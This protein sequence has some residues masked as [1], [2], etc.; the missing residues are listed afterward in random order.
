MKGYNKLPS[1][2]PYILL[3]VVKYL[4]Q[5]LSC[6]FLLTG[7]SYIACIRRKFNNK[8]AIRRL[9]DSLIFIFLSFQRLLL[10]SSLCTERKHGPPSQLFGFI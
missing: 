8:E 4:N 10:P 7:T 2:S 1:H 9:R 6:R 3:S 5:E